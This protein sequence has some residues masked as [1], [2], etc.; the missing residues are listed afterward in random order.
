MISMCH[1]TQTTNKCTNRIREWFKNKMLPIII[2]SI[3][4]R[5]QQLIYLFIYIN[6]LFTT[7][8]LNSL[9]KIFFLFVSLFI[10]IG[11]SGTNNRTSRF[12]VTSQWAVTIKRQFAIDST[13]QTKNHQNDIN[14][15]NCT[16]SSN[17]RNMFPVWCWNLCMWCMN[18][19]KQGFPRQ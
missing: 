1:V 18:V 13:L 5:E 12:N 3:C 7:L 9:R 14:Y 17:M 2:I 8:R 6:I 19:G 11:E 16:F 10:R 15:R 4:V